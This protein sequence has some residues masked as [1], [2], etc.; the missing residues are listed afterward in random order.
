M[1]KKTLCFLV[2][3]TFFL[4]ILALNGWCATLSGTIT[5]EKTGAPIGSA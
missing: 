4:S 5:D 3:L 2:G 1:S